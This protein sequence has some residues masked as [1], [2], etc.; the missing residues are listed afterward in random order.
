MKTGIFHENYELVQ[1][2]KEKTSEFKL[3]ADG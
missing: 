1:S 3:T 2:I